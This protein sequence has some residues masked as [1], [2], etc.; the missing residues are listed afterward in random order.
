L[1]FNTDCN[2]S[3]IT[4]LTAQI[5]EKDTKIKELKAHNGTLK[6]ELENLKNIEP[7]D[8]EI[9]QLQF[10]YFCPTPEKVK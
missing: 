8:K 2:K 6:K 1:L 9:L 7:N 3:V 5:E 10:G 4:E